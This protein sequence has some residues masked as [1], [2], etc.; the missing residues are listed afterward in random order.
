MTEFETQLL[1]HL[2]KQAGQLTAMSEIQAQHGTA[3][4]VLSTHQQETSSILKKLCEALQK[5]PSKD[6]L[7]DTLKAAL[8]P[9][10]SNLAVLITSFNSLLTVSQTLSDQL[11]PPPKQ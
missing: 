11:P 3:L 9:L 1:E 4:S 6:S 10:E 8:Q 5:E 7:E 2:Q